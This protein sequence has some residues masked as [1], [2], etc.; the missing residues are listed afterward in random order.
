M[1]T[2][3]DVTR[4]YDNLYHEINC[5]HS[6]EG[7]MGKDLCY[8]FLL[9]Q[10][11]RD[12]NGT[13]MKMMSMKLPPKFISTVKLEIEG[14]NLDFIANCQCPMFWLEMLLDIAALHH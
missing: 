2:M 3:I 14:S 6:N 8:S 9:T 5:M 10:A 11:P 1:N 4:G 12:D 13:F 7:M